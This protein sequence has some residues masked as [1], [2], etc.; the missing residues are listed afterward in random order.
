MNNSP[1]KASDNAP[2]ATS[3]PDHRL[4]LHARELEITI[5]G[6]EK[7]PE[8]G[9]INGVRKTFTADLP[10]EFTEII[11]SSPNQTAKPNLD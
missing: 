10:P 9:V 4:M 2:A 6:T 5:P 11:K 3:K 7:D 8:T 1:A